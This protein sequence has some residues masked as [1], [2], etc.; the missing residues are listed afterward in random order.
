M[1]PRPWLRWALIVL[2]VAFVVGYYAPNLA[3][4]RRVGLSWGYCLSHGF[5]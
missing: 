5:L 1:N 4:C 3:H 2:L